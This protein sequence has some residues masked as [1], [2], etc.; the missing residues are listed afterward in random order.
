MILLPRGCR[1]PLGGH[2]NTERGYLPILASRLS[3]TLT[4]FANE[5]ILSSEAVP[6]TSLVPHGPL[7]PTSSVTLTVQE[8]DAL[9]NIKVFVSATD[10][11]PLE[12][13]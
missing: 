4:E 8:K 2:T 5:P 1:C 10:T 11:H 7:G 12:R 3:S 13:M 6:P 9:R